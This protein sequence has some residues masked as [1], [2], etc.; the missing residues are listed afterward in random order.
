MWRVCSIY[1]SLHI[2]GLRV[3]SPFD[4][5]AVRRE[6]RTHQGVFCERPTMRWVRNVGAEN[7]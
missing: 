4:V 1:G 3:R 2:Y 7:G 5:L 6:C